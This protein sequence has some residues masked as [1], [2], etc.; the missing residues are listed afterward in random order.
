MHKELSGKEKQEI[1]GILDLTIALFFDKRNMISQKVLGATEINVSKTAHGCGHS[2][3][4]WG[5]FQ[6]L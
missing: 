6:L 3:E 4:D 2:D 1:A 5:V